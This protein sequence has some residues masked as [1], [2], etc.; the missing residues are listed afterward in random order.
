MATS[1]SALSKSDMNVAPGGQDYQS[2]A[3]LI[4]KTLNPSEDPL[5][6]LRIEMP[7]ILT[8][9]PNT[10]PNP[11]AD[12][13]TELDHGRAKP[14]HIRTLRRVLWFAK[15]VILPIAATTT[16]LYF[17]C[18]HLLKDAELLE[19]QR[20]RAEPPPISQVE[21]TPLEGRVFFTTIPRAFPTDVELIAASTDGR[22]IASVGMQNELV[23]I[24][25]R[26]H[27]KQTV[28][29]VDTTDILLRPAS[30]SAAASTITALCMN[31]QGSFCAVGTGAGIIAVWAVD[32][33]K[34]S[35]F[36]HFTQDNSS[37]GVV[38]LLFVPKTKLPSLVATYENGT[39]VRWRVNGKSAATHITPNNLGPVIK[40]MAVRVQSDNRLLVAFAMANGTLEVNEVT[41]ACLMLV[42]DCVLRA[43]NPTDT[44]V[45]LSACS[46]EMGGIH[47]LI[48]GAATEAGIISLWNGQTGECMY[49]FEDAFMDMGSLRLS[50][51]ICEMCHCCGEHPPESFT[52][53]FSAGSIVLFY[54]AYVSAQARRCSCAHNVPRQGSPRDISFGKRSRTTSSASAVGS[55]SPSN[56]RSRI[57][58]MAAVGNQLVPD[59]SSFPVS[60][61]GVHS[62]RASEKDSLR[63]TENLTLPCLPDDMDPSQSTGPLDAW[64]PSPISRA[65]AAWNNLVVA[66][67]AKVSCERG[68]WDVSAKA[69]VGI[70]R[71]ARSH[72]VK[73]V[74]TLPLAL[75]VSSSQGLQPAALDRWELWTFDPSS[76]RI[77]SA[78]LSSLVDAHPIEPRLQS[79]SEPPRLPFTRVSPFVSAGSHGLV[80]L[81]NTIG[82]FNLF[83]AT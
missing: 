5:L 72:R 38:D 32:D 23:V 37:A 45:K 14:H 42:P 39:A 43:G 15:I 80:G 41:D 25:R 65:S 44:T 57:A 13:Y 83:P 73:G 64:P 35:P 58:T 31:E 47:H 70:Y 40:C 48:I 61:H 54:T 63:R 53:S 77:Q 22:V 34:L 7:T 2:A 12:K 17:L 26:D 74:T 81:G 3:W 66:R 29:A 59:I 67:I 68:S 4:W 1:R 46:F 75:G 55:I 36:S 51:V 8:F 10:N 71:K 19:A 79:S 69:I 33:G 49:V 56:I 62:R 21:E 18:L 24:W 76:A 28:I 20:N 9:G 60:A 27:D 50:P 82:V 52:V 16:A 30:S 11:T 6:H 78:P